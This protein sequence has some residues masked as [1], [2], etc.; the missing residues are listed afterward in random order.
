[1]TVRLEPRDTGAQFVQLL[2][3]LLQFLADVLLFILRHA[4]ERS[5]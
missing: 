4:D 3:Q 1:M 5:N 2:M